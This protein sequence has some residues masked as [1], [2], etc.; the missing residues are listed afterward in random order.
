MLATLNPTAITNDELTTLTADTRR[1]IQCGSIITAG[2]REALLC[3]HDKP[4]CLTMQAMEKRGRKCLNAFGLELE[5]WRWGCCFLQLA[6]RL[7]RPRTIARPSMVFKYSL[8][9]LPSE[10]IRGHPVTHTESAMHADKPARKGEFH[11]TIALFD[12][13]TGA[14]ITGADVRARVAEIGLA[15]V[16][17]RLQPMEIADTETYGNYFRMSGNGPFRI[18]LSIDIPGRPGEIKAEFEHRH[19]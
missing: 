14:R 12:A 1:V 17:K 3:S 6:L 16:E 10:M 19:Q 7:Q 15:G 13:S 8:G 5:H 9:V 11:V 18:S 2:K 4:L